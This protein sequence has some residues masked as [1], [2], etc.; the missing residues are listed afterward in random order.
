MRGAICERVQSWRDDERFVSLTGRQPT[1]GVLLVRT[2]YHVLVDAE[3]VF[4]TCVS[5]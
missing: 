2:T 4:S 5:R 3:Y 1:G